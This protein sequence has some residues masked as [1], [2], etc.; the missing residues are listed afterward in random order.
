M[1]Q[2]PQPPAESDFDFGFKS[3]PKQQ[4]VVAEESKDPYS[5]EQ[6][7]NEA[8]ASAFDNYYNQSN[9]DPYY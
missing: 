1:P 2:A 6:A 8:G 7:Y 4:Q 5:Q 3:P 9:Q